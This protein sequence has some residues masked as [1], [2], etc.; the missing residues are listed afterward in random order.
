MPKEKGYVISVC[1]DYNSSYIPGAYHIERNDSLIPWV[2]KTDKEAARNAE[3]DGIR[4]IYKMERVKD[5]IY[6]DTDENRKILTSFLENNN[7]WEMM[8]D[9]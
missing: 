7:D 1:P 5:G 4:L 6:I 8:D 3:K 9:D 2:Y